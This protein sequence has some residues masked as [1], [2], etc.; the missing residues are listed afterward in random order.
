MKIFNIEYLK[1]KKSEKIIFK[2]PLR[3][4]R[5]ICQGIYRKRVSNIWYQI[6]QIFCII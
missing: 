1:L 6:I 5:S 3:K 4:I 2:F